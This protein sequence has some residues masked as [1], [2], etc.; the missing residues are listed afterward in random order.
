MYTI[1]Y[2]ISIR[3]SSRFPPRRR[4]PSSSAGARP[5]LTCG[6]RTD[7]RRS[8][9]GGRISLPRGQ[10]SIDDRTPEPDLR[11]EPPLRRGAWRMKRWPLAR[12][13]ALVAEGRIEADP[14]QAALVARLDRLARALDGYRPARRAS[15]LRR[16]IGARPPSRRAGS[17][18]MARSGAARRFLMDLFFDAARGRSASAAPISTPSWPTSTRG[19][20]PGGSSASAARSA[21][22]DPIAP[23]AAALAAEASLLCFDEFAVRDIADAMILARLFR[24]LFA[25]GVV[26]VATSN[27]APDDLYKRRAQP[28][29]VP[30]LPRAARASGC[31]VVALDARTD[32][33]LQKLARA[34]VYYCPA[35]ARADAR[36][37]RGAFSRLT[38]GRAASRS[39]STLLGRALHVP[40]AVDGVARFAFDDLCR[41]PLARRDY[42]ALARRLP[43]LCRRPHPVPRGRRAQRR[44][45][46]SS[47][48]STRSTTCGSS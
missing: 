15:A 20:T 11:L 38:G 42:L 13:Q 18:S 23:V 27:V 10:A 21:G 4:R 28:R 35:D 40:Q 25:A 1:V 45:S 12:Y 24:A 34:P 33:R 5:P 41:R 17:M 39:R 36:A 3:R 8:A 26:V 31:D 2:T 46:G 30:A 48:S 7:K 32:Y 14:A 6:A 43:H 22:D 44:A 37:R 19:S 29:A 16:L 9:R 47:R